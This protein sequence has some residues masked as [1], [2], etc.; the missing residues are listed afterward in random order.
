MIIFT[1][2]IVFLKNNNFSYFYFTMVDNNLIIELRFYPFYS[3][4][5][6]LKQKEEE[7][8]KVCRQC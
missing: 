6:E 7:N 2:L 1:H 4:F 8:E 5:F 3:N